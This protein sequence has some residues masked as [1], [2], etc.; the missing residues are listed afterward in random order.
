MGRSFDTDRQSRDACLPGPQ[1]SAVKEVE[2]YEMLFLTWGV[3]LVDLFREILR[4]ED[5]L[6]LATDTLVP[7]TEPQS[8]VVRGRTSPRR[9]P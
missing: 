6:L 4:V 3:L 2:G 8:Q 7:S 9:G 1:V 5:W